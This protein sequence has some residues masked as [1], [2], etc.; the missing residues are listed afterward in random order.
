[1]RKT[2]MILLAL[3][4]IISLA[5]CYGNT[6]ISDPSDP[7]DMSDAENDTILNIKID[8]ALPIET[9]RVELYGGGTAIGGGDVSVYGG[10]TFS[11]D[12]IVPMSMSRSDIDGFDEVEVEF[13][14][15]VSN[16]TEYTLSNMIVVSLG[17]EYQVS[18][19]GE[20]VNELS[21]VDTNNNNKAVTI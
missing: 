5:G 19:I 1:M 8:T 16:D 15:T 11:K 2:I 13:H 10:G 7:P 14:I 18:I 12:E 20:S 21:I 9:I 17:N 3:F 4:L 6:I